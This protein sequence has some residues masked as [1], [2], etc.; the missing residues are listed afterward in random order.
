MSTSVG[1]AKRRQ[2]QSEQDECEHEQQEVHRRRPAQEV[3]D[4]SA[5][6][7]GHIQTVSSNDGAVA[8]SADGPLSRLCAQEGDS[9]AQ[10]GSRERHEGPH[11]SLGQLVLRDGEC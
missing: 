8:A 4:V 7:I 6:P 10:G 11:F 2:E 3:A 9:L 5:V 1:V